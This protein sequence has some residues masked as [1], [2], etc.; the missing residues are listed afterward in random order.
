MWLSNTCDK[1]TQWGQ[2]IQQ[3]LFQAS[4]HYTVNTSLVINL[5]MDR[6]LLDKLCDY[7]ILNT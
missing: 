1:D 5:I 4:A 3:I 2:E 6:P 7:N